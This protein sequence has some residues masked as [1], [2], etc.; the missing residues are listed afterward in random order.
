MACL[1]TSSLT[2]YY[3]AKLFMNRKRGYES[4]IEIVILK[5]L[6]I[7]MHE[8]RL[9]DEQLNESRVKMFALATW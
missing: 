8:C 4:W 6:L 9:W 5:A 1:V 2:T 3:W 7:E